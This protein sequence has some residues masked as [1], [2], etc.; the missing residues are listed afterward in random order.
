MIHLSLDN[1][2]FNINGDVDTSIGRLKR[3][4]KNLQSEATMEGETHTID[5]KLEVTPLA[6]E[7]L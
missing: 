6:K 1:H 3:L 5:I 2:R 4:L 7:E